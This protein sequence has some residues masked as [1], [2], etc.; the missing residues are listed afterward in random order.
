MRVSNKYSPTIVIYMNSVKY[1]IDTKLWQSLRKVRVVI[2]MED[3]K[4]H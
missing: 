2:P 1:R 3:P 4:V